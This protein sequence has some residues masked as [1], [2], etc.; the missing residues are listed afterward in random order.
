MQAGALKSK[1]PQ[2][3]VLLTLQRVNNVGVFLSRLKLSPAEAVASIMACSSGG[4]A[5]AA[6]PEEG[7]ARSRHLTDVELE[8]L[9]HSLP[10]EVRRCQKLGH[11]AR[12][13]WILMRSLCEFALLHWPGVSNQVHFVLHANSM[14]R[15]RHACLAAMQEVTRGRH[16]AAAVLLCPIL[17]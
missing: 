16:Y 4:D 3:P 5:V 8:G 13:T 1:G 11:R 7:K 9:L 17:C 2:R 6:A 10:T 14:S 12:T 15:S